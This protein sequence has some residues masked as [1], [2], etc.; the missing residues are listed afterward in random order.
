M[1]GIYPLSERAIK[2]HTWPDWAG[3]YTLYNTRDGPPRYVGRSDTDVRARLMDHVRKDEYSF[4]RVTH[5]KTPLD[6]WRREANLYHHHKS[7]LDN[8]RHPRPPE[9]YSCPRCSK[10]DRA[11]RE[12]P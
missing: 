2:E 5:K 6:A 9:G 12:K 8:K 1:S 7:T 3:V 10:L 11:D 4:F